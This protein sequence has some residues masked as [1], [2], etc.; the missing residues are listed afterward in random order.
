MKNLQPC[1][2]LLAMILVGPW[3]ALGQAPVGTISG[4]VYDETG[5]VIPGADV[6]VTD[7]ATHLTRHVTSSS[8]GEFN[9]AALPA[10]LYE[11]RVSMQ[12]FSSLVRP[13]TV[14]A[15]TT[16][17]V[18]MHLQVGKTG[19]TVTV[20]EASSQINYESHSVEGTITRQ[21]IQDL[22]LNGRSFL[23]LAALEP[24][25]SVSA[26][27][28][29]QL[30][31]LFSVSILGGGSDRTAINVDGTTVRNEIE[32][33]IQQ[34]FSQE[35][36]QEFQVSSANFD[37]STDITSVGS[38]NMVTR[39]GSNDFHGSGYFYFRDHNIAAYPALNRNSFAPDPFFARRNPGF[40]VGGP[41]LKD[42]LFFFFNFENINQQQVV[43]VQP[44]L[45]SISGLAGNFASPYKGKTIGARFDF[46]LNSKNSMFARYSHDGNSAFG[47]SGGSPLPSNWLRNV[48]WSDQ[49][50]FDWTTVITPALVNDFHFGYTYWHNRNLF[51][52][53]SVCPDCL[54]LGLPDSTL[55]GSSN[56]EVGNTSNAT[57]GRDLRR[58]TF[59]DSLSWQKGT[60]RFRFG[61]EVEHAPGTGFW[62]YCDPGCDQ[63]ASPEAV[64][65]NIPEPYLSLFF[66]NLP[67]TIKTNADLMNL[68]YL[69]GVVGIGDPSQPPPYNIGKANYNNRYRLYFQDAWRVRPNFTVNYGLAWS[70]ESTLT[71]TDLT[72]PAYLAPLYGNDLRASQNN[73]HNFSPLVGFAWNVGKNN[74]TV[75]R[76]GAGIYYD[77]ENLWMRLQER[78]EIGPVG[79]GRI[80]YPSSGFTNI[81]PG[82]FDFSTGGTPI[83]IGAPLQ[84]GLTN[85]TLGQFLQIEQQQAP[86]IIASLTPTNLNDLS[87]R[88]IN[89]AK[90]ADALYPLHYPVQRSYQMSL[91]VQHEFA[92]D[93]VFT[94]DFVRRVFIHTNLG[95]IDH[96]DYYRY[97][98]GVQTPLIPI[99]QGNQAND[100]SAECSVGAINFWTPQGRGTY[101][102]FLLK[103]SKRLSHHLQFIVSDAVQ[104]QYGNNGIVN[105]LNY[106]QSWG[107]QGGRNVL[108]ISGIYELPWGFQVG[109]ISSTSSVGT[110]MPY[111]SNIDLTGTTPGGT[112]ST[113]LPGV[114]FN[115]FNDGCGK[116]DLAKAVASWNS[117]YAGHPDARGQTIPALILPPHYSL[118]TSFNSQDLRLTKNFTFKERYKFSVFGEVFNVLNIA[119]LGGFNFNID[120]VAGAGQTQ[121]FAFGQ[122]TSRAGQVF[123]SG[124]PRAFQFGGRFSF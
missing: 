105:S 67:T 43:T 121:T 108:T 71:N 20:E 27:G 113:P 56:F 112:P 31:A 123:G 3:S 84:N 40:W 78:S 83:P 95:D 106:E 52:D 60:H 17:T 38:I 36:V 86:A 63:L 35:V 51:A 19:D 30:N 49:T 5:A 75:I 41:I 10:S 42:K 70:F 14:E 79:N 21:Q 18:E 4:I 47:P 98:N 116:A 103:A 94:A 59:Q 62:G 90:S 57:Q 37:L 88:N 124:G 111:V 77:T 22:P 107:P 58:Y 25:V 119:N 117:T 55:L 92:K 34:N 118:G 39:T 82:I 72:K 74:K 93:F 104:W 115:C 73:Y 50:V 114:S 110:M 8:V 26:G 61:T 76:G 109:L 45:P 99:C 65:T 69:G 96:N 9:V 32:G 81:F 6:T 102:A 28:T 23:Q 85:L 24:G 87:V 46:H 68:P 100:P 53:S 120:Q 101:T 11:V 66:P 2:L 54:G 13:A 91:G 12:G 48:N 44:D 80:Q 7:T 29:S 33:G 16:T 122:P 1:L 64:R 97:I 89:I 15:G